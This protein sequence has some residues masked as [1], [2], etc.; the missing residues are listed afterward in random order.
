[1]ARGCHR[2]VEQGEQGFPSHSRQ[3]GVLPPPRGVH[4]RPAGISPGI[5]SLLANG[6]SSSDG[7]RFPGCVYACLQ[8]AKLPDINKA[9]AAGCRFLRPGDA[10]GPGKISGLATRSRFSGE[11]RFSH[12]R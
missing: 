2:A 8:P 10:G 4:S 1:M 9:E 7:F 12:V 6:A 11:S 5:N 3:S